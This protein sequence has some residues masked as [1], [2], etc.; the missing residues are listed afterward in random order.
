MLR[1]ARAGRTA[2]RT[3]SIRLTESEAAELQAYVA[4]VNPR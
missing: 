3:K 1:E 4:A 2:M